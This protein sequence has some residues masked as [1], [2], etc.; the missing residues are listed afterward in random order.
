MSHKKLFLSWGILIALI[1]STIP[2]FVSA[3][4]PS[5]CEFQP[6]AASRT[7]TM[8]SIRIDGMILGS[9]N[10]SP[11][12]SFA[13]LHRWNTSQWPGVD[14]LVPTTIVFK[15]GGIVRVAGWDKAGGG[16]S[17]FIDGEGPCQGWQI[18][19]GHLDYN[20]AERYQQGQHIGPDEVIG[21]P[22]CSG[23]EANCEDHGDQIPKHNHYTLGFVNN[24]FGFTDGTVPAYVGGYYWIHPARIEGSATG[25]P[26]SVPTV[27]DNPG[28]VDLGSDFF[29]DNTNGEIVPSVLEYTPKRLPFIVPV[30]A[31]IVL[32]GCLLLLFTRHYKPIGYAGIASV[33]IILIGIY[34]VSPIPE[35]PGQLI[36]VEDSDLAIG[37]LTSQ[38]ATVP[39]D[40]T[41]SVPTNPVSETAYV[42]SEDGKPSKNPA[43][44]PLNISTPCEIS[45][46]YPQ[47]TQQWCGLITYYA[48][49]RGL[50]PNLIAALLQVESYGGN[51]EACDDDSGHMVIN[52]IAICGSRDG[53]IG[54]M[55][56]MPRDGISGRK[57][58]ALFAD[59]P[60]SLELLN[61]EINIAYGTKMLQNGGAASNAREALFH[62]GPSGVGY[63]YAD[64]VLAIYNANR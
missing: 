63:S 9:G 10:I 46:S 5:A 54:L 53:A 17:L 43:D 16:Y 2:H 36:Y 3:Q 41:Q 31:Y 55:Q 20:P 39:T 40:S 61:P 49:E 13:G 57:Y 62:Y 23:F 24:N 28:Y 42:A 56:V 38:T 35:A 27:Q 59:R 6:P 45:P 14:Y 21:E 44:Y 12:I 33:F 11:D 47:I 25:F 18:F 50:D 30:W 22:G 48:K 7:S 8:E 19:I 37:A 4:A 15:N 1:F 34:Y 52:G 32:A 26:V 29:M 51:P 60:T 58:G 64:S